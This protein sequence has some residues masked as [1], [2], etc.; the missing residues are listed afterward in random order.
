MYMSEGVMTYPWYDTRYAIQ[1]TLKIG[2]WIC[3]NALRHIFSNIAAIECKLSGR[4]N[5]VE[6]MTETEYFPKS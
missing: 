6:C 5:C 1:Q 4:S 2:P 3:N